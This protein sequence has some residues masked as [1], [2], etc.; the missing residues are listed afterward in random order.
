[1]RVVIPA[2]LPKQ[3]GSERLRWIL[4]HELA[5]VKRRDHLVR[6]L[7]WLACVA[8]WWNPIVWWTRRNLRLDEEVACDAMVLDRLN[9]EPRAYAG[10]REEKASRCATAHA[11]RTASSLDAATRR[12][13]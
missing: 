10:S 4:A 1:M 9:A 2:T 5:H 12:T 11:R 6:W 13:G 7:E 3:I 8:F